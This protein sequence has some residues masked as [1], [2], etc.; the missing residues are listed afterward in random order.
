MTVRKYMRNMHK[1][2]YTL[3]K[4]HRSTSR[5]TKNRTVWDCGNVLKVYLT[6]L[7][8]IRP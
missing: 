4:T 3:G 2:M 5:I 1:R 8:L 6:C 7:N